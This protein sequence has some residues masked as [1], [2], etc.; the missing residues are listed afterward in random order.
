MWVARPYRL[1][2]CAVSFRSPRVCGRFWREFPALL[3]SQNPVANFLVY[4]HLAKWHCVSFA[5]VSAVQDSRRSWDRSP[6]CPI[7]FPSVFLLLLPALCCVAIPLVR[8]H[9]EHLAYSSHR[10]LAR[11]VSRVNPWTTPTETLASL[12]HPKP[13]KQAVAER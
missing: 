13:R 11:N 7:F 6:Q 5:L 12:A 2:V 4:G 9:L 10:L 3:H 1:H 8:I